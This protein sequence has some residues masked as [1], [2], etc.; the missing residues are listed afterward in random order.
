MAIGLSFLQDFGNLVSIRLALLVCRDQLDLGSGRGPDPQLCG[1]CDLL[2]FEDL[3][4]HDLF[5]ASEKLQNSHPGSI[6]GNTIGRGKKDIS[7]DP[8]S[9]CRTAIDKGIDSIQYNK[10]WFKGLIDLCNQ[11]S[12]MRGAM[13][14]LHIGISVPRGRDHTDMELQGKG[15]YL[16]HIDGF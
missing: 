9:G 13:K 2:L 14:F 11:L 4:P 15:K 10:T 3:G 16:L 12:L 5:I 6:N 7:P 1:P 8:L